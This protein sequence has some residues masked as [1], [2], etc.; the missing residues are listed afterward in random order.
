MKRKQFKKEVLRLQKLLKEKGTF[1]YYN[2]IC[3]F[4][5]WKYEKDLVDSTEESLDKFIGD[6][7][8]QYRDHSQH[9]LSEILKDYSEFVKKDSREGQVILS[10]S[11]LMKILSVHFSKEIKGIAVSKD[12]QKF[13]LK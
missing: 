1:I 8:F 5:R 12:F 3:E 11:D 6:L 4:I 13:Y 10:K 7:L 9:L 2:E